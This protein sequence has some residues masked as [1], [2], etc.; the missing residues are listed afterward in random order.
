M[1]A[2][3]NPSRTKDLYFVA[4]GTGGHA[5]AETLDQHN[6][7]VARWRAAR[8]A[9]QRRR[10][11]RGAGPD[12]RRRP[13]AAAADP[14]AATA[15]RWKATPIQQTPTQKQNGR[16]KRTFSDPVQ[17][18]KKDPL[19]NKTFDLNSPQNVPKVN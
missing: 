14:S 8:A 1:E 3:A 11:G 4:D 17:N 9:G 10:R 2:V 18:T 15:C 5:F 19:L 7:N 6:R 13:D 12:A 16:K